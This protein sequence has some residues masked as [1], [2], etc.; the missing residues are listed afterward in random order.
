MGDQHELF[1][2]VASVPT[3]WRALNETAAGGGGLA[4]ITAATSR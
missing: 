1:G 4:R 3:C 2:L